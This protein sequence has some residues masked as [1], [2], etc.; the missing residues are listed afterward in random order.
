M[1]I[2]RMKEKNERKK[3]LHPTIRL[4]FRTHK[5]M[6]GNRQKEQVAERED[7]ENSEQTVLRTPFGK[8]RYKYGYIYVFT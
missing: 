4:L 6:L 1:G 2:D 7:L 8:I 3:N 5:K